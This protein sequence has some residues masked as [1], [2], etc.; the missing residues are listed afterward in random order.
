[1]AK[2]ILP[3]SN[4]CYVMLS[5]APLL[6]VQSRL[7]SDTATFQKRLIILDNS[8]IVLFTSVSLCNG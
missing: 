6:L 8:N 2:A 4:C 7:L 1:M 3:P 5:H